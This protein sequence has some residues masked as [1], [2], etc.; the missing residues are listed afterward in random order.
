MSSAPLHHCLPVLLISPRASTSST[1][2]PSAGVIEKCGE[3]AHPFRPE[4]A[5]PASFWDL[6]AATPRGAALAL[7]AGGSRGGSGSG[8]SGKALGTARVDQLMQVS[9]RTLGRQQSFG[10]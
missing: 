7:A 10:L 3:P 2:P 5:A 4:N 9:R 8:A 1:L 6:T